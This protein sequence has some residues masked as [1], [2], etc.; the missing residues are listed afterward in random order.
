MVICIKNVNLL[1]TKQYFELFF[2]LHEKGNLNID[3]SIIKEKLQWSKKGPHV[4]TENLLTEH[5]NIARG[6]Y[7]ISQTTAQGRLQLAGGPMFLKEV[8][9]TC[10]LYCHSTNLTGKV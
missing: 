5:G 7:F 2:C 4:K 9:K 1:Q 3:Q 6:A 8:T 10:M